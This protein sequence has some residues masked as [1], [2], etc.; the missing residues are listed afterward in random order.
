MNIVIVT[1]NLTKDIVVRKAS[2]GNSIG[3]G[4]IAVSR[5]YKNSEGKYDTDFINFSL[6]GA[7]ADFLSRIAHKGDRVE[8]VGSWNTRRYTDKDNVEHKVDEIAVS[9]ANKVPTMAKEES[10]PN[11]ARPTLEEA[12]NEGEMEV[13]DDMLP[14]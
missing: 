1:G 14:F 6:F 7:T 8:L 4:S 2:N 10:K 11:K 5:D 13:T 3:S 9:K 12:Y